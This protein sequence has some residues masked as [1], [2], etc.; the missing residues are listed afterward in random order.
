MLHKTK[1]SKPRAERSLLQKP[2]HRRIELRR[3]VIHYEVPRVI[4]DFP[5]TSFTFG[6]DL[7]AVSYTEEIFVTSG[8]A[9]AS[10]G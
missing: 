7:Y 2:L 5:G 4:E 9:V 1:M 6:I 10:Y 3:L 8:T